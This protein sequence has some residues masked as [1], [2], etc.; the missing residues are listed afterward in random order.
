MT[1]IIATG[2]REPLVEGLLIEV[3]D[4]PKKEWVAATS[5]SRMAASTLA[6]VGAARVSA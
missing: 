6:A 2:F 1:G 3:D 4:P 5:L